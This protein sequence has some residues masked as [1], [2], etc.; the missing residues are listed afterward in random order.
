M[1]GATNSTP[2][3]PAAA[4]IARIVDRLAESKLKSAI[5]ILIVAVACFLPGL[6]RIPPIDRAETLSAVTAQRMLTGGNLAN[7]D[8]TADDQIVGPLAVEWLTAATIWATGH[9]GDKM[10]PLWVYRLAPAALALAAALLTWWTA[11]ALTGPRAALYC[12]N[13]VPGGTRGGWCGAPCRS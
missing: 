6:D 9:A 7:G 4:P 13:A 2:G 11:L 5:A 3:T 10:A 12:R 1:A 8:I